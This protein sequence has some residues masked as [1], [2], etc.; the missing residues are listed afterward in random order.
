MDCPLAFSVSAGSNLRRLPDRLAG[1]F[2]VPTGGVLPPR[3]RAQAPGGIPRT[4]RV[5]LGV[6]PGSMRTQRYSPYQQGGVRCTSGHGGTERVFPVPTGVTAVPRPAPRSHTG[7]SRTRRRQ[8]PYGLIPKFHVGTSHT[9]KGQPQ[10]SQGEERTKSIPH[11]RRGSQ[12]LTFRS[13]F[14]NSAPRIGRGSQARQTPT[15]YERA[16][17]GYNRLSSLY[18]IKESPC[19]HHPYPRMISGLGQTRRFRACRRDVAPARRISW[20]AHAVEQ[21]HEPRRHPDG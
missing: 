21:G 9:C 18:S 11:A 12:A 1:V 3:P 17:Y 6:L 4:R 16:P 13:P 10:A 20:P 15:L 14:P 7:T 2:P 19:V 8:S 5:S